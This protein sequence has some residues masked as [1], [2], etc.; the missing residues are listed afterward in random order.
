[1]IIE[2][3]EINGQTIGNIYAP[4]SYVP[5]F[6]LEVQRKLQEIGNFLI[7]FAE[8]YNIV[9]DRLLDKTGSPYG[10]ES[11]RLFVLL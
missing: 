8:D 2:V 3:A 9:L 10:K 7:I 6:F 11:I 1:M 4:N 5:S